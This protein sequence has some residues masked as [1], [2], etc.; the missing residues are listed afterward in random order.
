MLREVSRSKGGMGWLRESSWRGRQAIEAVVTQAGRTHRSS[1]VVGM[2]MPPD[3]TA[4]EI[5]LERAFEFHNRIRSN[6]LEYVSR[7]L[8]DFL[9]YNRCDKSLIEIKMHKT[10]FL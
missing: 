8:S 5:L 7:L 10:S 1:M 6:N 3:S 4:P 9:A 2:K